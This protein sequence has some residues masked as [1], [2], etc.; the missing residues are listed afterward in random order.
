MTGFSKIWMIRVF[1]V[2]NYM[3]PKFPFYV[4]LCRC[5]RK[6]LPFT[7]FHR[8]ENS[9][10]SWN[11]ILKL[12]SFIKIGTVISHKKILTP[13]VAVNLLDETL[14]YASIYHLV[15]QLWRC[16]TQKY[17]LG[18]RFYYLDPKNT[19]CIYRTSVN[20]FEWQN[21]FRGRC[22]I[23]PLIWCWRYL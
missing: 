3:V 23:D 11:M 17:S 22:F 12:K 16:N 19:R 21:F 18:N 20:A 15:T 13:H 1:A 14:S 6:D 9:L 5:P 4:F 7:H 10:F 8:L 2:V